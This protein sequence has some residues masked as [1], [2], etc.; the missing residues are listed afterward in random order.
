MSSGHI[1]KT[2][3]SRSRR[4]RA[5]NHCRQFKIRC[6]LAELFPAP[7]SACNGKG[8]DCN[9]DSTFKPI[10]T[11]S[12]LK[13]VTTQLTL[14]QDTLR[15]HDITI[16]RS[17]FVQASPALDDIIE[18]PRLESAPAAPIPTPSVSSKADMSFV[19]SQQLGDITL[20]ADTIRD[21]FECFRRNHYLYFPILDEEFSATDLVQ[22]CPLLFWTVIIISS[23]YHTRHRSI[24][25]SLFDPYIEIL[26]NALVRSIRS[27]R[28]IQ[29]ILYLCLW[30]LR[31]SK[32]H[33]DPSLNYCSVA[34]NASLRMGLHRP[35]LEKENR[36]RG[37]AFV[38]DSEERMRT[39]GGCLYLSTQ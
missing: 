1:S 18:R 15:D 12:L 31:I 34:V 3:V 4:V 39:W 25:R 32:Q 30:P 21:L 36:N 11:R 19:G 35:V 6:D 17:S 20:E 16:P 37:H 9:V 22:S 38:G 29:A 24:Y 13:E 23:R 10:R 28:V 5:C 7:C 14:I 2:A 8:R 27:V 33:G 26:S